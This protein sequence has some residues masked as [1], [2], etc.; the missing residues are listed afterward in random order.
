MS[1]AASRPGASDLRTRALELAREVICIEA[2]TLGRL[3]ERFDAEAFSHALDLL[4]GC[5]GRIVVS[6]MGKS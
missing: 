1:K 4:L 2:A 6:G 3:A 5:H